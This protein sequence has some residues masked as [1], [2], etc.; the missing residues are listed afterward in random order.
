MEILREVSRSDI[1]CHTKSF[2]QSAH[3][4][5]WHNKF[6][7]CRVLNSSCHFRIDGNLIEANAGDII[8]IDERVVHQFIIDNDDTKII[9][10]QFPIKLLLNFGDVF[11]PLRIHIKSEELDAHDSL[12]EEIDF[13]FSIL[14]QEH[15]TDVLSE[16]RFLQSITAALYLLLERYFPKETDR[17]TPK[18]RERADFYNIIEYV[19]EHFRENI[20]TETLAKEL[21]FSRGKLSSLFKFFSGITV[22]EYINM[23]RVKHANS[24]LISG[25]GV[26]EAAMESGFQSIR[27]F[28]NVYRKIMNKTPSEYTSLQKGG[29]R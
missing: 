19:N 29:K 7:I 23:L 13:F 18:E 11:K 10:L 3:A 9:I 17:E 6:E 4:F 21:C 22:N 14:L 1:I 2:S 16:N 15:K 5:H 28:N 26:T 25:K 12:R 20:N 24:L 8:A 27:T